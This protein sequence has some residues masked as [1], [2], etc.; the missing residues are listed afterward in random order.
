[1]FKSLN[2][3]NNNLKCGFS[4]VEMLVAIGIFM[5]IMTI[6]ISSL[7]SIVGANKKSQVIKSTVEN[8][9]FAIEYVSRTMRTGTNYRCLSDDLSGNCVGNGGNA[10]SFVIAVGPGYFINIIYKF[11]KVTG[12]LIRIVNDPIKGKSEAKLISTDSNVNI[13]NMTFYVLG[14][15]AINERN[16]NIALRTQPRVIV[17]ASGSIRVKGSNESNL[18]N[19]QTSISQRSR[20]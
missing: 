14:S 1:M 20:L 10:V 7:T 13:D 9:V 19:L 4:L 12:E 2:K 6:A 3:K 18:F 11:D 16:P 17:T 5:S 8:V 15:G